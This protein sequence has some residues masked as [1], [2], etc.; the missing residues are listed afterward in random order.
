MVRW[1]IQP[2]LAIREGNAGSPGRRQRASSGWVTTADG[3]GC[4]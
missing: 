2:E 3:C 4:S 1:T